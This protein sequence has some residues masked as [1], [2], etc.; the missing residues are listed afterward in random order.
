VM[1][2]SLASLSPL[3]VL[4]LALTSAS[5][6]QRHV[7]GRHRGSTI[8]AAFARRAASALM[9]APASHPSAPASL[10]D[11]LVD[12]SGTSSRKVQ[13]RNGEYLGRGDVVPLWVADMCFRAPEPIV[14]AVVEC[15]AHGVYGYTDAP[16]ELVRLTLERLERVYGC[17]RACKSWLRWQ[18]GLACGLSH[19]VRACC[20]PNTADQ[21]VIC[22]PIYPP[23]C[24]L[25]EAAGANVVRVPLAEERGEHTLR[26]SIDWCALEAAIAHPDTKLLLWCSPHNPTGRCWPAAE[27]QRLAK[28]CVAHDVALCSDEVWGELPLAPETAPFTSALSLSVCGLDKKLIV[29]TSPSKA[30]NVAALDLA[31]AIIP[32]DEMRAR[33]R[34]VGRDQAEVTAFGYFAAQAAYGES[35][36]EAWRQELVRYLNANYELVSEALSKVPG[37]LLTQPEASYLV[38]IDATAALPQRARGQPAAA[39]FLDHGVGLSDGQPFGAS[40]A[41]YVRLNLATPR[42]TLARGVQ[43]VLAAL[44]SSDT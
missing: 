27:M 19:A 23:F 34:S 2:P 28:L 8:D 42:D 26:Y 7:S 36:C 38:W 29:L 44:A 11:E 3:I 40:S 30:F 43:R 13:G 35:A 24:A 12:R 41:G 9:Q 14:R 18:P 17:A 31:V 37:V 32:D 1:Q 22:T 5:S 16:E 10:F 20:R 21:V 4:L 39:F 15:A 25:T 33:F 6:L